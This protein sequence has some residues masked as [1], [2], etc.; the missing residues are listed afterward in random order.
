MRR[1]TTS[2]A[3]RSSSPSLSGSSSS[4]SPASAASSIKSSS[5]S[6]STSSDSMP[7]L[8]IRVLNEK[9]PRLYDGEEVLL[10]RIYDYYHKEA[11]NKLAQTYGEDESSDPSGLDREAIA[12]LSP[13]CG[14]ISALLDKLPTTFFGVQEPAANY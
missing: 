6:R 8:L 9:A 3:S 1:S 2:P 4:S 5:P 14:R 12:R 10:L 7:R 11:R 13:A